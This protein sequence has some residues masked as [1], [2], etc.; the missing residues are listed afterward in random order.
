VSRHELA[1]AVSTAGA[2][3]V[4]GSG[5]MEPAD[6]RSEIRALRAKTSRPFAVNLPLVNVRPDGDEGIVEALARVIVEER[7]RIVIT[8]AGSPSRFT[9]RFKDAGAVVVHVVPSVRLAQ[10]AE[11][12]GVDAIVAE[13][14]ESGG[15]VSTDGLST[16]ALVPQVVDAV[17]VP[18]IA[19]GGIAD[20]RQVAAVLALGAGAAQVGT[21]YLPC[22]ESAISDAWREAIANAS[23]EATT[24][25]RSFT[26]RPARAFAN[27]ATRELE[28]VLPYPT[29]I[30]LTAALRGNGE[31]TPMFAGQSAALA[32]PVPAGEL[33]RALAAGAGEG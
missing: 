16:F 9:E 24:I 31:F 11:A 7:V 21:A 19:A 25:T 3:G 28:G 6:L 10:K 29:Q 22:P 33:T 23:A 18:V 1:A 30:S 14:S 26:G 2:L 27:R 5:G 8:G 32:Q 13:S 12:A 4:L 20:A 17:E 15:H